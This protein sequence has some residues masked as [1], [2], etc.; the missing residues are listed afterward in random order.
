LR[1]RFLLLSRFLDFE[2]STVNVLAQP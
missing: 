2:E 1:V